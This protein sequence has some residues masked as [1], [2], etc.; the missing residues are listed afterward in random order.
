MNAVEQVENAHL[1]LIQTV[2]DLPEQEWD[3]PTTPDGWSVKD[4]IGH[5]ASYEHLFVE[6]FQMV[7][8]ESSETP[9]LTVY[10]QQH[11]DFNNIQVGARS[12][13]TAQQVL[14]EYEEVQADA[15]A[16]LARI[17]AETI[18]E[19]GTLPM[20]GKDRSLHDLINN[21]TM[22]TKNHCDGISAF[23]SREKQ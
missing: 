17:P 6:V 11:N 7:L 16:L 8:G 2:D 23:R 9:Y 13:H 19:K 10:T 3:V 18:D 21:F 1:L 14:D 5:L 4:I 20:Y 22:H 15:T 12:N